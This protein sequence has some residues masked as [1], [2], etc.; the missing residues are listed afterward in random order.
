MSRSPDDR[1]TLREWTAADHPSPELKRKSA[2]STPRSLLGRFGG[3]TTLTSPPSRFNKGTHPT[4][5]P[6]RLLPSGL[7]SPF[8]PL[9]AV[10]RP[11]RRRSLQGDAE[12]V[13]SPLTPASGGMRRA[14]KSSLHNMQEL[15][16]QANDNQAK[17]L[18]SGRSGV[19]TKGK[20]RGHSV[21]VKRMKTAE[22]YAACGMTLSEG[23]ETLKR[24]AQALV[25]I[26]HPQIIRLVAVHETKQSVWL[27]QELMAGGNV[28]EYCA[29]NYSEEKP[30]VPPANLVVKWSGHLASAVSYLHGLDPKPMMHRDI[31]P[32][33]CLLD[34]GLN[35]K[36]SDFGNS[37][38]LQEDRELEDG[39]GVH[40]DGGEGN[41]R[42]LAPEVMDLDMDG[43]AAYDESAD[44]YSM[45][46]TMWFFATAKDPFAKEDSESLPDKVASGLRPKLTDTRVARMAMVNAHFAT[47]LEAAWDKDSKERPTAQ[48]IAKNL[49]RGVTAARQQLDAQDKKRNMFLR[50][51]SSLNIVLGK[52]SPLAG[53]VALT[54]RD[55]LEKVPPA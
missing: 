55:K 8:S 31:K 19:L 25:K 36:L 1:D 28:K 13:S 20:W 45:A 7:G 52:A 38:S 41:E 32:D 22:E 27:I 6:N 3:K 49:S 12:S 21:A 53:I 46:M 47:T 26:D 2:A 15:V 43:H 11:E 51:G 18:G 37:R 9:V 39:G 50:M 40:D 4:S 30:W 42:Y 54:P 33:N 16:A 17:A 35:L 5:P 10:F 34:E 44:V 24:E 48:E 23:K 29:A 14:K